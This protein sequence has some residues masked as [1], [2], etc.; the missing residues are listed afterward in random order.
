MF[1]LPLLPLGGRYRPPKAH[2]F[3]AYQLYIN[4]AVTRILS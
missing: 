4:G 2:V 3:L 1:R